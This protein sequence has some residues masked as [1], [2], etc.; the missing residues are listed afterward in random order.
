MAVFFHS[1]ETASAS[2][3]KKVSRKWRSSESGTGARIHAATTS[4]MRLAIRSASS[5]WVSPAK[6]S[7]SDDLSV[8]LRVDARRNRARRRG[9][10]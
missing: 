7:S 8:E 4:S 3:S 6:T 9:L 10:C 2:L 1:P 5:V